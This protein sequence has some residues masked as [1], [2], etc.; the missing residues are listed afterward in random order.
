MTGRTLPDT[1]GGVTLN[2][3]N[4]V[5]LNNGQLAVTRVPAGFW[6]VKLRPHGRQ[7]VA[8]AVPRHTTPRDPFLIAVGD[9][10]DAVRSVAIRWR[11]QAVTITGRMDRVV[12]A[13]VGNA[14]HE[15]ATASQGK[16]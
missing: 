16:Q 9:D 3:T 15:R 11:D 14:T 6:A 12:Y 13:G 1:V 4:A 8:F 5:W 10:Q 7:W 2:H